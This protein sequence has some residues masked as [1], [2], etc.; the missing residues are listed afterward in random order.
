VSAGAPERAERLRALH[1]PGAPLVLPNVWDAASARVVAAQPGCEA[2]ATASWAIAASLGFEDHEVIPPALMVE[3][4]GRIAGAVPS[5]PVTADL[6]AGYDDPRATV[7][8]AVEAGAVGCNLEDRAEPL[9]ESVAR[10]RE[11]IAGGDEAGVRVVVNARTDVF[12]RSKDPHAALAG[13]VERGQAYL[14][15]GADCFFAI[16]LGDADCIRTLVA[17]VGAV[18][19]F[20]HPR[21]PSL[22]ELRDLGVVR[23]SVGPGAMGAAMAALAQTAERLLAFGELP[24]AMTFRPPTS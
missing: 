7:R 15:A 20:A 14:E 6:E 18:S 13:A 22:A 4:V 9:A 19:V 17:E 5:L 2:L 24:A 21:G 10:V 3:A 16:G 1:R 11:G 12:L 8:A 23:I